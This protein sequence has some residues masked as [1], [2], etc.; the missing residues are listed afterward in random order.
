MLQVLRQDSG[1][2]CFPLPMILLSVRDDII[3]QTM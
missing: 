2:V 1:D 3:A